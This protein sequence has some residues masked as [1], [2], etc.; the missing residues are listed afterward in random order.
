MAPFVAL[1]LRNVLTHVG[2]G[3]GAA[4]FW[5]GAW[6]ILDDHLFP[7]NPALSAGSSLA[8][9]TVGMALSQGLVHKVEQI[10]ALAAVKETTAS[11]T[12]RRMFM[13]LK[14]A[15]FGALYTIAV[16]CVLVWRGTWLGWVSEKKEES[17]SSLGALVGTG[18]FASVLAPPAATGIIRD[19]SIKAGSKAYQG[20]A[21]K[22]FQQVFSGSSAASAS[23]KSSA[24]TLGSHQ[25]S[26]VLARNYQTKPT[27]SRL[28]KTTRMATSVHK[29]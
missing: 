9:G 12:T 17:V 4:S 26:A 13:P 28:N 24:S 19:F 3:M 25:A 14:V 18:L 27:M 11:V 6:Y 15:R 2:V 23:P 1:N 16:S 10:A 7:E 20:P 22:I 21:Q 5:R 8:M 29:F